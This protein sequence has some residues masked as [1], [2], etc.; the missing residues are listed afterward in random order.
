MALILWI[1]LRSYKSV[2]KQLSDLEDS[3]NGKGAS[4]KPAFESLFDESEPSEMNFAEEEASAGY[5]SY[6]STPTPPTSFESRASTS[7]KH[8]V[9]SV[10]YAESEE[11]RS[12]GFDLRQAIVYDTILRAKYAPESNY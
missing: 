11:V 9:G 2:R 12:N 5:Y 1:G 6:E 4:P 10:G 3:A 7:G 8:Q